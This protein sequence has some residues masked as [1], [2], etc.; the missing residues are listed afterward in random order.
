MILIDTGSTLWEHLRDEIAEDPKEALQTSSDDDAHESELYARPAE[1]LFGHGTASKDLNSVHPQPIHIFRLWQ[2]FLVNCN[3]LIKIFHAPTVQQMILDASGDLHSV[4][5]HTEALMFAIYLLAVTSLK[6]QDCESMFDEPRNNLLSRY[7]H[8]AQQALINAKF[9]KSLNLITLQ[10]FSIYLV[11]SRP[12]SLCSQYLL[13]DTVSACRR[14][15]KIVQIPNFAT[16]IV[17][18]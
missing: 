1:F 9:L 10:A 14:E 2:T 16:L 4:P 3:P 18:I 12:F 11:S 17:L 8:A 6:G 13:P 15:Y 7:S 5:R